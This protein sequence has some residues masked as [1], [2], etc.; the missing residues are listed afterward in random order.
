MQF[1]HSY[2]VSSRYIVQFV[3][4]NLGIHTPFQVPTYIDT[5]VHISIQTFTQLSSGEA[6]KEV[7]KCRRRMKEVMEK[8]KDLDEEEGEGERTRDVKS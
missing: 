3:H 2:K 8:N 1:I 5:H 4:T 6:S 7:M